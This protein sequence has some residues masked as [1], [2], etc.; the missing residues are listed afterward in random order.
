MKKIFLLVVASMVALSVAAQ[1]SDSQNLAKAERD[2]LTLPKG[3]AGYT[4]K[5]VKLFNSAQ[6]ISVIKYSPKRLKTEIVQP[7]KLTKVA[8][9]AAESGADFAVNAGYWDVRID[10]PSTFLKLGGKQISVTADFEK[11][12]VDGVVCI[13]KKGV[14]IDYCKAGEEA[15]YAAKYDDILASG[16]MLIDEGKS[17]DHEAYTK[18]MVDNAGGKP[19]GAFYTYTQRHPRTAMGTD[20]RGNVYLIVVDGRSAGNAEGV[21]IA[22]LTKVCEW[23]GLRDAI[24]LDGGGSSTMWSKAAGVVSYPCRNKKYDHAGDRR[25]SSCVVVKSKKK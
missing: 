3:A 14:V 1:N 6:T 2:V 9:T 13:A 17:V 5:R 22:E 7:E 20:K 21:T 15:P 25:V 16:P 12:R 4:V 18:G 11:E 10:K 19:V 24:N 23:L 8:V